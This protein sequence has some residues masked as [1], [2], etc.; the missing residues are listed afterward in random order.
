MQSENI[1]K[2]VL[3]MTQAQFAALEGSQ[4]QPRR[5]VDFSGVDAM[6]IS[7]RLREGRAAVGMTRK[8]VAE[9]TGVPI[10]TLEKYENGQSEPGISRLRA[11][12]NFLGLDFL[13]LVDE[14]Q[15]HGRAVPL[16]NP[17]PAAS[18]KVADTRA[19]LKQLAAEHGLELVT[20]E[21]LKSGTPVAPSVASLVDGNGLGVDLSPEELLEEVSRAASSFGANSAQAKRILLLAEDDLLDLEPDELLDLADAIELRDVPDDEEG[22][23]DEGSDESPYHYTKASMVSRLLVK[24]TF[25][26]EPADLEASSLQSLH[27]ELLNLFDLDPDDL[28]GEAEDPD[29]FGRSSEHVF[30][31]QQRIVSKLMLAA[32]LQRKAPDISKKRAYKKRKQVSDEDE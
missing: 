6:T 23:I 14:A 32:L 29:S 16:R 4:T 11:L 12:A 20:N 31:C 28:D 7:N 26:F 22:M 19:L 18:T 3:K 30:D 9:A 10:K 1:R 5:T 24:A 27:E 25:G 8:Q 13:E 2:K 15:D 21:Q 17:A